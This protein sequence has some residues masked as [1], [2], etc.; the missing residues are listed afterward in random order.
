M[1][2]RVGVIGYS[3][4][5]GHPFSFSAI[6]NGYSE[7]DFLTSGWPVINSYLKQREAEEFG[8]P[9]YK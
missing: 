2:K 4:G 3:A 9:V 8:F 5:N 7:E 6:I 1:V